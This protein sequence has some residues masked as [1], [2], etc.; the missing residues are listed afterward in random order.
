MSENRLFRLPIEQETESCLEATL[1]HMFASS[2]SI[3]GR[4][5]HRRM[6]ARLT[7]SFTDDHLEFERVTKGIEQ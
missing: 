1:W 3:T 6:V 2:Q 7:L 5:R 4:L